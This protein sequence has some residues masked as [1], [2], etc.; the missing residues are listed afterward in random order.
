MHAPYRIAAT[1]PG[2]DGPD[3]ADAYEALL[4]R[5]ASRARRFATVLCGALAV[6]SLMALAESPPSRTR[7]RRGAPELAEARAA[8]RIAD[9]RD[10]ISAARTFAER[11]Q[12]RFASTMNAALDAEIAL[13]DSQPPCRLPLPPANHLTHRKDA[14]P[15]L[16]LS[17]GDRHMP[18]PS[19]AGL[20]TDV[21]RAEAYFAEGRTVDA[22]LQADALSARLASPEGPL[23]YDVVLVTT[24]MRHPVRTT[25]TSFEP[26]ELSGRAYVYD[27]AERRVSCAGEIH[28]TS[29][30]T[31]EYS[32]VAAANGP[33]AM[34]EGPRLAASLDED[35]DLQIQRAVTRGGLFQIAPF[36]GRR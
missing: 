3:E 4:R 19:V 17:N 34:D 28:A 11:E 15:L 2:S 27:F 26:G 35:L 22:V 18:S 9:A 7:V 20:L 8:A 6:L 24:T 1:R 23:R 33:A 25:S 32:Y 29:S 31:I 16:V 13:D 5:R 30:Q 10:V 36:D 21:R 12:A 14:F